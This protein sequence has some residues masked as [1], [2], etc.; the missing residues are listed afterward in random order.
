MYS[1]SM[2]MY[3]RVDGRTGGLMNMDYILDVGVT[4]LGHSCHE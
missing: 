3:A 4:E 2:L 1:I